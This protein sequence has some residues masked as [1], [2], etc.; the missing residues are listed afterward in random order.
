MNVNLP[1]YRGAFKQFSGTSRRVWSPLWL[2]ERYVNAAISQLNL[3]RQSID[4]GWNY[5]GTWSLDQLLV[6]LHFYFICWDKAQNLLNRLAMIH[7]DPRLRDLWSAFEPA[8]KP[9]NDARNHLEH[10][11]ERLETGSIQGD[12][13]FFAGERFD[14]SQASL[15]LLT[16]MYEEVVNILTIVKS[17]GQ[18]FSPDEWAALKKP[19]L[20]RVSLASSSRK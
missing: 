18:A 10:I 3:V 1:I 19:A 14:A 7:G 20:Q 9:F 13:F 4:A 12:V 8:C 11:D 16:D 15:K 2:L 5:S 17:S 6:D